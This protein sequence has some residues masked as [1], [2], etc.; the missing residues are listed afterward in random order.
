MADID[1]D[2]FDDVIIWRPYTGVWYWLKSSSGYDPASAGSVQF[3]SG[4]VGD[5]PMTGDFNGDGR[6]DIAVWRPTDSTFYW[7]SPANGAGGA[8]QWGVSAAGD[9]PLIGDFDGD[10]RSDFAVW[11]PSNGTF[12]WVQSSTNY[13]SSAAWA[14]QWGYAGV[15][16]TPSLADMDGDGKAD[17]LLWR[18]TSGEWFWL[19]SSKNYSPSFA[20]YGK[21]AAAGQGDVA[22]VK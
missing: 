7:M 16:D 14:M 17:L 20:G 22:V 12:Y 2:G 18:T 21:M 1:G 19:N 15:G 11:R 6:A 4:T 10:H 5:M 13:S 9:I 8:K 3:G